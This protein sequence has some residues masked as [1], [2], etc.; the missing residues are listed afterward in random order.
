VRHLA[1]T[2][3]MVLPSSFVAVLSTAD[4]QPLAPAELTIANAGGS[5]PATWTAASQ[6]TTALRAE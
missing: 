1:A 4:L 5:G 3:G 2:A 6:T